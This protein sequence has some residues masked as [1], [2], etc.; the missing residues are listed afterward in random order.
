MSKK[1]AGGDMFCESLYESISLRK[2]QADMRPSFFVSLVDF[3]NGISNDSETTSDRPLD[4]GRRLLDQRRPHSMQY[5][6]GA[7]LE[8]VGEN[9][10]CPGDRHLVI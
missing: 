2:S 9:R 5:R 3:Q 7:L 8:V 4:G 1:M 10:Q 6:H